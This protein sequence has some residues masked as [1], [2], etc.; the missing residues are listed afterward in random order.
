MIVGL[1]IRIM[2]SN[3]YFRYQ[4]VF[5]ILRVVDFLKGHSQPL[6]I[7]AVGENAD[8]YTTTTAQGHDLG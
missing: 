1:S 2:I 8:H 5:C 4:F 3:R 7:G 6:I